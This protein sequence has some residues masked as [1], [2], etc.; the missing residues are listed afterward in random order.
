MEKLVEFLGLHT[1]EGCLLIDF[2]C[3]EQLHGDSYHGSAGALSVTG[4]E[5]PELAVLDCELHILH[6]LEVGLKLVGDCDKLCGADR[7]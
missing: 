6:I 1:E 7:H 3:A 4:L 2:A 5:H